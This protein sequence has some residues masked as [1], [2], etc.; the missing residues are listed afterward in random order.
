MHQSNTFTRE[1]Q[2]CLCDTVTVRDGKFAKFVKFNTEGQFKSKKKIIN[3][4]WCQF[5][6]GVN[7]GIMSQKKNFR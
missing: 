5:F 1:T 2:N 6:I 4:N 7:I 3:Q